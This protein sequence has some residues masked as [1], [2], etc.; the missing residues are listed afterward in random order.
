MMHAPRR[1]KESNKGRTGCFQRR[2]NWITYQAEKEILLNTYN[3]STLV[4]SITYEMANKSGQ[5][6]AIDDGQGSIQQHS[7]VLLHGDTSS[8]CLVNIEHTHRF[9]TAINCLQSIHQRVT[10]FT[11]ST[12]MPQ[13]LT[14]D[15]KSLCFTKHSKNTN[16]KLD[17]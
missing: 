1:T 9:T 13:L 7:C 5:K 12:N 4:E 6:T 16:Y 15:I 8:Q 2:T 17:P 3:Y 11:P 14:K 10:E